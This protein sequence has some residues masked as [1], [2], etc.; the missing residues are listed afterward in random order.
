MSVPPRLQPDPGWLPFLGWLTGAVFFFYAWILRVAPSI[1]VD[2]LMR[3][4][5]VGAAVLGNLSAAYFYGYAGMQI[6]VGMLLDRFGPRRLM[7]VSA[8]LCGCGAAL[9]ALGPSLAYVTAGRFLIGASAAFSLVGAMAVASQW[10]PAHRFALLSGLAMAAGMAGGVLGQA[11]LRIAVEASDWR[12]TSLWLALGGVLISVASWC[13]VRDRLRGT[14]GLGQVLAGLGEAARDR[15]VLLL[16]LAGLGANGALL[17]FAGLWGVPFLV[18]A[19]DLERTTAATLASL[20]IAGWGVGAPLIGWLSDRIGSRKYPYLVGIAVECLALATLVWVPGL[21]LWAIAAL[22]FLIGFAGASMITSFALVRERVRPGLTGTAIGFLN[23]MV[24]GA[25]ALFQPLIGFILDML[26]QGQ[27]TA[28]ARVYTV[29][30]YRIAL[31][32]LILFCAIGFFA[33]LAVSDPKRESVSP[34]VA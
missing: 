24:T 8:L 15:Q 5:S 7:T 26:W 25:G 18:L 21:P 2:E 12:T 33:V 11:P 27:T 19:Y 4:L 16:S 29:L 6:P 14:G 28:G 20:L 9:F 1:M 22:A 13:F 3:D 23:A 10:F 31:S 17:G 32:V 30:D 34:A